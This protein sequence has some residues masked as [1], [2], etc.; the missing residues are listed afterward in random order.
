MRKQKAFLFIFCAILI[1]PN[2]SFSKGLKGEI[3]L[4]A[5]VTNLNFD[6]SR[7]GEYNG[8]KD[9]GL[10][11]DKIDMDGVYLIADAELSYLEED[12]F[13]KLEVNDNNSF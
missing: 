4:G 10:K 6:T 9:D 3:T 1:H 2:F 13:F 5:G 7:Y 11:E 12:F 8:I